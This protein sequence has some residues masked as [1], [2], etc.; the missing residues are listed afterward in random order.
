MH[1]YRC[2]WFLNRPLVAMQVFPSPCELQLLTPRQP[3]LAFWIC[4]V[5][6]VAFAFEFQASDGS[7]EQALK[8]PF[9]AA[10]RIK[11]GWLLNGFP[12]LSHSG[13][14]GA[15]IFSTFIFKML[16]WEVS[17]TRRHIA[18]WMHFNWR[19]QHKMSSPVNCVL[20]NAPSNSQWPDP[21]KRNFNVLWFAQLCFHLFW[22]QY[23]KVFQMTVPC[24]M[25]LFFLC[26]FWPA[27]AFTIAVPCDL[28][29]CSPSVPR[30][31]PTSCASTRSSQ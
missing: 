5:R 10:V 12:N 30:P 3:Q 9:E 15:K 22:W 17:H 8:S 16:L 26:T 1:V 13:K 7:E 20:A 6:A 19:F 28:P 2:Y 25:R 18:A 29:Q 27:S 23:C 21:S 24:P 31:C 11:A 14:V 4:S